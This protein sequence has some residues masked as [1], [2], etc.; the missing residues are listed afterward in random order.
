MYL[1]I[2]GLMIYSVLSLYGKTGILAYLTECFEKAVP[3]NV[4]Y[5]TTSITNVFL[6]EA[7]LKVTV[8]MIPDL[9]AAGV[10]TA[11]EMASD[12]MAASPCL[13]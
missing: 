9:M 4:L 1:N 12:M 10:I 5:K 6:E 3:I 2:V 7:T 11:D 13:T 8:S